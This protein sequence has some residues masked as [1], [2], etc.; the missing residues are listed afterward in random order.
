MD[1]Q[2]IVSTAKSGN[3]PSSWNVWPLRRDE[4]IRSSLTW[5]FFGIVGTGLLALIMYFTIPD[6]FTQ[7]TTKIVLSLAM[8]LVLAT[9]GLGGLYIFF[10]HVGRYLRAGNY[11]LI[12]TPDD[13][14]KA[15][16]GNIIAV[17][18]SDIGGIVLRGVRRTEQSTQSPGGAFGE[19]GWRRFGSVLGTGAAFFGFGRHERR[20]QPRL[21]F[22]DQRTAKVV[23]VAE[24]NAFDDL[25]A[26]DEVLR[27]YVHA[28][29]RSFPV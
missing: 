7:G 4:L 24:D 11:F 5:L 13:F 28:K 17:P 16:P 25:G 23:I 2:E 20:Q 9:M 22:I 10:G 29:E 18:M 21:S 27:T 6:N 15:V 3:V 14:V 8:Y 19:M 12:M 26:L 1:A